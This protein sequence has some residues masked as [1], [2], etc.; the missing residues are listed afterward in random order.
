MKPDRPSVADQRRN[1]R[2]LLVSQSFLL[3]SLTISLA[4]RVTDDNWLPWTLLLGS[5]I[6]ACVVGIGTGIYRLSKLSS[7]GT[8]RDV[9]QHAD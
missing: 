5:V 6:V 2:L 8:P 7:A 4:L 3:C 1:L 9:D